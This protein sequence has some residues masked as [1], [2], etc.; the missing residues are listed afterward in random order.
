MIKYIILQLKI[1]KIILYL[2]IMPLF[3]FF[4]KYI[5][6]FNMIFYQIKI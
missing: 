5:I 1:I 2:Y 6:I 3:L 4:R